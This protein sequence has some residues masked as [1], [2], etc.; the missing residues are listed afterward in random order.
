[1]NRNHCMKWIM[2]KSINPIT[3][4]KIKIGG[5]TYQKIEKECIKQDIKYNISQKKESE[6]CRKWG[7]NKSINPTTGRKIKIGGP[8]YKKIE[9]ECNSVLNKTEMVKMIK[10]LD[11][12]IEVS[13][14]KVSLKKSLDYIMS[15]KV[16][17]IKNIEKLQI[18]ELLGIY[19]LIKKHGDNFNVVLK[20]R[21][22]NDIKNYKGET[23]NRSRYMLAIKYLGKN[24]ASFYNFAGEDFIK[25][26]KNTKHRY[27]FIPLYLHLLHKKERSAHANVLIYDNVFKHIHRFE[28]HGMS[29]GSYHIDTIDNLLKDYFKNFGY[30]YKGTQ[31]N[32][33]RGPQTR[34]SG[35]D[36]ITQDPGGF[37]SFWSLIFIDFLITNEKKGKIDRY[38]SLG[39]VLMNFTN[40]IQKNF[41]SYKQYIRAYATFL[42][43][44][45]IKLYANDFKKV[46]EIF[47]VIMK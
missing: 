38:H 5:P 19:Y 35:I 14:E 17:K 34:E 7:E 22:I 18:N 44:I 30:E 15:H 26:L 24:N 40:G 41:G 1:M 46:D 37:C 29:T 6:K 32:C 10:N 16:K 42:N 2:K 31:F 36:K 39:R 13:K 8:T 20:D 4:R 12:S 21:V 45:I 33:L 27:S 47:D 28:P 43:N 11:P 3:G 25:N 9:K 23:F